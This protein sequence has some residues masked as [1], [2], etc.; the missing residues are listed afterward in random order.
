[1]NFTNYYSRVFPGEVV[2]QLLQEIYS[3]YPLDLTDI[4]ITTRGIAVNPKKDEDPEFVSRYNT[5]EKLLWTIKT[6]SIIRLDVAGVLKARTLLN[7]RHFD[8]SIKPEEYNTAHTAVFDIDEYDTPRKCCGEEKRACLKCFQTHLIPTMLKMKE[9]LKLHLPSGMKCVF[10]YTGGRGLHCWV[11]QSFFLGR[12][13]SKEAFFSNLFEAFKE[14]G[15][16][17][18]SEVSTKI[19]HPLR[20]PFSLHN[21]TGMAVLPIRQSLL[22]EFTMQGERTEE[23]WKILHS[24]INSHFV[25]YDDAHLKIE[26]AVYAKKLIGEFCEELF[27][28]K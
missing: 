23:D 11:L 17:I 10:F 5:F 7:G 22:D 4:M 25:L 8:K 27:P 20:L 21:E 12:L 2:R 28:K 9:I 16:K 19:N 3:P 18:D 14:A 1:M 15:I 26:D 6:S 13:G 24:E